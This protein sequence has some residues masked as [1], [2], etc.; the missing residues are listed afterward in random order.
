MFPFITNE[1]QKEFEKI[2]RTKNIGSNEC[3]Y[4]VPSICGYYGRA[5]R[6]MNDKADRRLC[7][8]CSLAEFCDESAPKWL[9]KSIHF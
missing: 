4:Y 1:K 8:G 7:E 5:C 9:N 6:Q 3:E 2:C